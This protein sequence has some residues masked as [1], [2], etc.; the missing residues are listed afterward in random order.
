[1]RHFYDS[2]GVAVYAY[3]GAD[4]DWPIAR[5]KCGSMQRVAPCSRLCALHAFMLRCPAYPAHMCA[6]RYC[7][8]QFK[9]VATLS[10]A[11]QALSV[12]ANAFR[13]PSVEHGAH[14]HGATAWVS[15]TRLPNPYI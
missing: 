4:F 3:I 1:M 15:W 10:R 7:A 12:H 13:V 9:F 11:G 2:H 14:V 8:E 5:A 6:V